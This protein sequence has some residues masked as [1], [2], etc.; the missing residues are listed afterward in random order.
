MS[1]QAKKYRDYASECVRLAQQA[2]SIEKRNKLLELARVWMDA[3]VVEDQLA[4]ETSTSLSL[5]MV[6]I[7]A[8][9][10]GLDQFGRNAIDR[11]NLFEPLVIAGL[12]Q[13]HAGLA[14]VR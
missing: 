13:S 11:F 7:R 4:A 14:S 5:G 1:W 2:D 3:A 6:Q 10:C 9:R 12:T 8:F